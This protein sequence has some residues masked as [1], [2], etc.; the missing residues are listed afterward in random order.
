[1][2]L[3]AIIEGAQLGRARDVARLL[4]IIE[5]EPDSATIVRR[6]LPSGNS[7][8]TI[9]GI[10]GPPGVGKSTT[11]SALV[12]A[13]RK[14]GMRIAV[15]AVD[16][17]SPFSGGALLGDR[18]RMQE[19]ATDEG[20]YIRSMAARGHLGG[21]A[22]AVPAAMDTLIG[23]GFDRVIVETVGVGQSE[24]D[25]ASLA[26]TVI[27]LLAP[28]MGDGIQA[29]K[30]GILEIGDIFVVNKADR[31]GADA[32]V[33]ELTSMIELGTWPGWKPRVLKTSATTGAGIEELLGMVQDHEVWLVESG[34]RQVRRRARIRTEIASFIHSS[35]A[36]SLQDPRVDEVC[37]AVV[38]GQLDAA[39]AASQILHRFLGPA[40][41]P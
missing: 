36:V 13:Y 41:T 18:I 31:D 29:A 10:T 15:L 17:S 20:V 33:R 27:V 40:P 4:S 9:I 2:S 11:T 34:E 22:A 19:H 39:T 26:D 24:I 37:D 7:S 16:P 21:L 3:D 6:S 25:I 14:R 8:A 38:A 35:V 5:N 30:A 1:V 12:T 28:G 32:T 23:C